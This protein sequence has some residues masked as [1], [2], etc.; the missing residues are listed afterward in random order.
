[1]FVYTDTKSVDDKLVAWISRSYLFFFF[2]SLVLMFFFADTCNCRR[3]RMTFYLF[4]KTGSAL[5]SGFFIVERNEVGWIDVNYEICS[6]DLILG[7]CLLRI[8]IWISTNI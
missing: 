5:T 6:F 4:G 2:S 8:F 7:R 1:M 3:I